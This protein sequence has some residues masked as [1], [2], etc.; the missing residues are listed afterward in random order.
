MRGGHTQVSRSI[1]DGEV[2]AW[3]ECRTLGTRRKKEG[4]NLGR[5]HSDLSEKRRVFARKKRRGKRAERKS[6][7][8][9]QS[10]YFTK[11]RIGQSAATT[12]ASRW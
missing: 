7:R 8:K 1:D 12:G 11:G 9:K 2:E 3:W 6:A 10:W 5:K 4:T